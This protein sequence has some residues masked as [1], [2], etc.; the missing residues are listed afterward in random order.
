[1]PA[2]K[3]RCAGKKGE[4]DT[5][6]GV[7]GDGL[8]KGDLVAHRFQLPQGLLIVH[9]QELR[10]GKAG[11]GE[12][13]VELFAT[14]RG[15]PDDRNTVAVGHR[16]NCLR[17]LMDAPMEGARGGRPGLLPR[18]SPV[19]GGA[20]ARNKLPARRCRKTYN[21]R[22]GPEARSEKRQQWRRSPG[23]LPRCAGMDAGR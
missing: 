12:C 6:K 18:V 4:V 16:L 11:F 7:G 20:A 19:Y 17:W 5:L 2:G 15:C 8:D 1:M 13:L 3:L 21:R 23:P 14:N 9:Q 22:R 10:G